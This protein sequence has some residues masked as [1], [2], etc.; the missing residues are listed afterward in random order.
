M[1][2]SQMMTGGGSNI[3]MRNRNVLA[4]SVVK[5]QEFEFYAIIDSGATQNYMFSIIAEK[6]LLK[7]EQTSKA[8]TFA[9]E[10]RSVVQRK[11]Q[12]TPVKFGPVKAQVD[13]TDL[14]RVPFDFVIDRPTLNR[15]RGE[16]DYRRKFSFVDYFG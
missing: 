15:L 14:P 3:L 11:L 2:S 8:V 5:L 6:L 10:E 16:L 1:V 13:F 7:S 4:V 12:S 9:T